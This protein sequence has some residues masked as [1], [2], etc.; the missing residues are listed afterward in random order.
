[1]KPAWTACLVTTATFIPASLGQS[2]LPSVAQRIPPQEITSQVSLDLRNYFGVPGVTGQ[3]VQFTTL[4]GRFNVELLSSDAP[5]HVTNFLAY[6]NSRAYDNTL[7]HRSSQLGTEATAMVQGGGYTATTIPPSILPRLAPVAQEYRLPNVRGTLAA[8]RGNEP[9]SAT[10]EWFFNTQDNSTRLGPSG[11]GGGYTVFGRVL[12]TGMAIVDAIGQFP[13]VNIAGTVFSEFPVRNLTP[14]QTQLSF[15]NYIVLNSVRT[16]PIFPETAGQTAVL[17]FNAIRSNPNVLNVSVTGSTL[18]LTPLAIGTA[19]VTVSAVDSNGNFVDNTFV[20]NVP[21]QPLLTPL[22]TS[23]PVSRTIASGTAVVFSAT[24]S[25]NASYQWFRNGS[26]LPGT[27]SSTLVLRSVTAADAGSY[28]CVATN[29]IGSTT[30]VPATLTVTTVPENDR[31]RLINLSILTVAGSGPKT[32]TMGAV[33]GPPAAR[34]SLP[35]VVRAVGPTL[36]T[37]FGIDGALEDPQLAINRGGDSSA[38]ASNDNWGGG[39]PLRTAFSSVGAFALPETSLDSAVALNGSPANYTVQVTGKGENTGVVIAEVYEG[40]VASRSE[41]TPRLINL[42]TLTGIDPGESLSVGFVVGGQSP[43]T[44]LVRG[45]GPSLGALFA[46]SD[47][48]ED[49]KLELFDNTRRQKIGENEDWAGD[50]AL[51]SVASAVGAFQLANASTK[52]AVMVVTLPPGA[53][54]ARLSGG[55]N[56]GGTA[57]VEVYE[58][59]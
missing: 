34:G 43:V 6:A 53:Y 52:D 8:A 25:G 18:T 42:S 17:G 1:M 14:G 29:P 11:A 51:V 30:S 57:I 45:V 56:A 39:E 48:M 12:G 40:G 15:S 21:T 54:S 16:I 4:A 35:L 10:S 55:A 58:L 9:D 38:M 32:L 27:T 47:V 20:V 26:P 3:V 22:F 50:S 28:T 49:P 2:L 36:K 46:M 31:G 44:V 41:T 33:V 37:A 23:Q 19:N 59:R 24:A 13:I 5:R 7:F